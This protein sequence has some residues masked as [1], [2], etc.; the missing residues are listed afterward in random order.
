MIFTTDHQHDASKR[1]RS[2]FLTQV[3]GILSNNENVF[4][5]ACTNLPWNLDAAILRRFDKRLLINLPSEDDRKALLKH[6]LRK[7]NNLR[8]QD[9][10]YFAKITEKFSGADI[11][12]MC[13]QT[14]MFVVREKMSEIKLESK[15]CIPQIRNV[16]YKDIEQAFAS[17]KPCTTSNDLNKYLEWNHKYGSN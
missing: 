17:M 14:A 16:T 10:D 9:F 4:L 3:D 13:K 8:E 6:Y 1:F 15:T 7:S 11:K 5:L 2:E 12:S